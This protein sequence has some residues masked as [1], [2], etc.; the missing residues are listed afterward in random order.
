MFP[1]E[2]EAPPAPTLKPLGPVVRA[3][4][5]DTW[6]RAKEAL[7]A[8]VHH[9]HRVRAWARQ[10]YRREKQRGYEDGWAAGA[11]DVARLLASTS[12]RV[13]QHMGA[14]EK[15]LPG[16][17]AE[18]IEQI[19][20]RFHTGDL[21]SQAVRHALGRVRAGTDMRLRVAPNDAESLRRSLADVSGP[22]GTGRLRIE[23]DPAMRPG[24]CVLCSELGNVELGIAAQVK[25][26]REGLEL[27][28]LQASASS[29]AATA[30]QVR[31]SPVEG[32]P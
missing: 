5:V 12:A 22:S 27:Q 7:E 3:Q 4:E 28:V 31:R 20:G 18:I 29:A 32:A 17:I 30:R 26:L 14:L 6:S 10:A 8:A 1:D 23:V 13:E 15:E 9:R 24:A 25:A 2:P 11:A 16:L 21:L 19:L